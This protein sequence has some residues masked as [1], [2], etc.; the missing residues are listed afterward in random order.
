MSDI[1][2]VRY[3]ALGDS[4]TEGLVDVDD[5]GQP[6]G[7]ADRLADHLALLEPA[8]RYANL[9]VRGTLVEQIHDEQLPAALALRPDLVTVM[10]GMNDLIRPKFDATRAVD[11]LDGMFAALT[12][13]G[14]RVATVTFPAPSGTRLIG[15][16]PHRR[17]LELNAGIR[18]VAARRGVTVL[19]TAAHPIT[20]DPRLW[21]EDRVHASPAGHARIAA[22]MAHALGL[23]GS[24]DGW[25]R[26]LP[27]LAPQS[28]RRAVAADLLWIG[29]FAL[30]WLGRRL[31][32]RSSSDGRSAKRPNLTTVIRPDP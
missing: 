7:W 16:P 14:A 19:D 17:V 15:W 21:S 24:D 9:A 3:V 5:V 25:T 30:P 29:R 20:V 23:P 2:Y 22:A 31:T 28:R 18:S 27:P 32:G 12:G 10:A 8:V 26:P 6:R 4:Q 11:L 1:R 13:T